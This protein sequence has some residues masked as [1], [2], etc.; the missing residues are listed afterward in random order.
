MP[1]IDG[2][3]VVKLRQTDDVLRFQVGP[4]TLRISSV[5]Q[6]VA[7]TMDEVAV[8]RELR[9][10]YAQAKKRRTEQHNAV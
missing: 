9:H 8:L 7:P 5:L 3:E 1:T 6:L 10:Q 2:H 4:E